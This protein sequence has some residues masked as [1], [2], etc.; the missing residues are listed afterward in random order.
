M[1]LQQALA[2]A[3]DVGTCEHKGAIDQSECPKGTTYAS[4]GNCPSYGFC[5]KPAGNDGGVGTCDHIGPTGPAAC[6]SN[7]I[8]LLEAGCP[9]TGKCILKRKH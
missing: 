3:T 5:V 2:T 9:S 8:Y 1:I 6:R 7:Q 4:E